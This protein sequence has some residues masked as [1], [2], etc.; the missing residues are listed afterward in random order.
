MNYVKTFGF[1]LLSGV[2]I[3]N[4]VC[5]ISLGNSPFRLEKEIKQDITNNSKAITD[6]KTI[7]CFNENGDTI[8]VSKKMDTTS[9]IVSAEK[10]KIN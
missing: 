8:S 7:V 3:W 5:F 2:F 4:S 6:L 9:Y 1:G 10:L